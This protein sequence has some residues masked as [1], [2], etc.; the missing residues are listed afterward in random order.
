MI[1]NPFKNLEEENFELSSSV[2]QKLM[3]NIDYIQLMTDIADL[4]SVKYLD[5]VK[6]LFNTT[7]IDNDK[8]QNEN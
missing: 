3:N 4:F 5:V 6:S 2:K 7:D 1:D 8:S